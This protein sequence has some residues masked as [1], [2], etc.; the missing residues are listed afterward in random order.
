MT[1]KPIDWANMKKSTID[2]SG[3]KTRAPT[4]ENTT[5]RSRAER[6]AALMLTAMGLEWEYEPSSYQLPNG[7]MYVPDFWLPKIGTYIEVKSGQRAERLHKPGQLQQVF[8]EQALS[9]GLTYGL[10]VFVLWDNEMYDVRCDNRNSVSYSDNRDDWCRYGYWERCGQCK[11]W[12]YS[13]TCYGSTSCRV[14]GCDGN[15]AYDYEMYGYNH[16]TFWNA[17]CAVE[18]SS[19]DEHRASKSVE[20]LFAEAVSVLK[21]HTAQTNTDAGA[22]AWAAARLTESTHVTG[23]THLRR[24]GRPTW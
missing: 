21:T 10:D 12:Q 23:Y 24:T 11:T 1:A 8:D 9:H 16:D 3:L 20:R 4:F 7:H 5:F 2:W 18:G 22:A 13:D 19:G 17:V 6:R 14:N 15:F